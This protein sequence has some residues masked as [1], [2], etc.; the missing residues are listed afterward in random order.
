MVFHLAAISFVAHGDAETIYRTNVA[1]TRN[2]LQALAE[3][4]APPRAVLLASSAN[5][6]GN[7]GADPI[8]EQV[9]PLPE[10]DYAV[11]K[12][13][14]EY[15]ARLWA[16]RLPITIVRPFNYTGVGQS[17]HFLIPKLVAHFRR[18]AAKI[19]LGNLDIARD[20][21]DVRSVAVAYRKLID[22]AEPGQTFN[23]C[24]GRAYTLGELIGMLQTIAGYEIEVETNPCF[25]RPNEVRR[26]VGD[27]AR[28]QATVGELSAI[29]LFDTLCWMYRA[30]NS[31]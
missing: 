12:L 21:S 7:A 27:N 20:F 2:L 1:G 25:V 23:V 8:G 9:R 18:R 11:S 24:S 16:A 13:A 17:D 31:G 19:E 22:V 6:Y 28:L 14:M 3:G 4:D 5:I 15:M 26:L 29:P 30:G 10:N